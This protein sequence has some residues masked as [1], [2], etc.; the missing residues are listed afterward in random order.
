MFDFCTARVYASTI[1]CLPLL[2]RNTR[3]RVRQ[4]D[5]ISPL[6]YLFGSDLLQSV[7]NDLV[8]QG[9]LTLPIHTNDPDFPIVQYADDTLLILP[10]DKDQLLI[11]KDTLRKFSL[12][13]GL[14]INFD[15]SQLPI[16][17]PEDLL[18]ELV[19]VFQCQVGK[20]PH[21]EKLCGSFWWRDVM[22][23]VDN[24]RGVAAVIHGK[25][26]TL[27]FWSDNWRVNGSSLPLSQR[28]PSKEIF[29]E[30]DE[31][32]RFLFCPEAS[33]TPETHRERGHVG[34]THGGAAQPGRAALVSG[35]TETPSEAALSPAKASVAKPPM[36][37]P[38]YEN[39]PE[40]AAAASHLGGFGDRL[41]TCGRG[42][43]SRRTLHRHDRLRSDE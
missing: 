11:I 21:E 31:T 25:G 30:L 6:F 2:H 13:T 19:A 38:R 16:N 26:D 22:K 17:V 37:E 20:V 12:S 24:F 7:L 14:K 32:P 10:A 9:L 28:N 27:L 29:S 15:K 23:H 3:P 5:P 42:F 8:Q 34:P 4:G 1:A 40:A 39:L 35:S 43:I 41:G 33:R 36:R 18:Q